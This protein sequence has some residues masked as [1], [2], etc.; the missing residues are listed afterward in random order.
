M[1]YTTRG[2]TLTV[3]LSNEDRTVSVQ[4]TGTDT[5]IATLTVAQAHELVPLLATVLALDLDNPPAE[6]NQPHPFT[7]A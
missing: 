7:T 3:H 5:A 1:D 2:T 4:P 6:D